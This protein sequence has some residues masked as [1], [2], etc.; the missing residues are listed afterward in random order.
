MSKCIAVSKFESIGAYTPSKIVSTK[1]LMGS[2]KNKSKLD[3]E[4]ITGIKN[5]RVRS[6]AEDSLSIALAAAKD[7]LKNSKYKAEDL[8]VI[9]NTS[10]TR[11]KDGNTFYLDPP[12]SF[13]IQEELNAK[14][15]IYFDISNACAGMMT[16]AFILDN[17]IKAGIVRNGMIVSGECITPIAETAVKEMLEGVD[18]QFASLTVGD[19]GAAF[20]LDKTGD[21]EIGI[22]FIEL[23]TFAKHAELCFGMPSE[24][25]SGVAMYTDAIG[26]HSAALAK[27]PVFLEKVIERFGLLFEDYDIVVPHQ[28]AVRAIKMGMEEIGKYFDK[29]PEEIPEVLVSVDQ[30]GNTSSTAVIIALYNALKENRI[31]EGSKVI[32]LALASGLVLGFISARLGKLKVNGEVD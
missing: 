25:N 26:I 28:T 20:I 13:Y 14:N 32:F 2:L 7:C 21:P 12:M 6:E 27:I 24:K 8:D 3:L 22:D 15:A 30:Y 18:P 11:F 10:I 1:E 4:R 9:I 17:M 29:T 31:K 19:A 23:L 16:G 5:R